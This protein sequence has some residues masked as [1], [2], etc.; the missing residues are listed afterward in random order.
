MRQGYSAD[1]LDEL[2]NQKS[3][4]KGISGVSRDFRE[5]EAAIEEDSPRAELARDLYLHR[6]KAF[7]GSM[8]MSLGG[9]DAIVFTGGIGEHAAG[10]RAAACQSMDFLEVKL[11]VEKNAQSPEDCEVATD[12]SAVRVLEIHT[13]EDWA[14]T[15]D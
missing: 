9:I 2:L 1:D 3:G 11:D 15:Q 7:L 12:E 10:I 13:Q 4:L 14:I 6:L 5:I 8:L